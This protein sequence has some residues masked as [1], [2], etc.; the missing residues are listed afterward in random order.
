MNKSRIYIEKISVQGMSLPNAEIIFEKGVNI[1]TGASDSGKS[2]IF[3]C[4]DYVLGADAIPKD[5]PEADGYNDVYLQICTNK[6]ER[7]TLHRSLLYP[8]DIIYTKSNIEN[9]KLSKKETLGR[10]NNTKNGENIS[11]FLLNLIEV[12]DVYL[13]TNANNKTKK[14]SFRDIAK[15]TLVDESRII[16]ETSP[17]YLSPNNYL[18]FTYEKS[19]FRYLLTE[20]SDNSAVEIEEPKIFESRIK[21]KIEFI[22]FQIQNKN[23]LL[24]NII[25]EKT[26]ITS[27]ELQLKL[28][29]LLGK[30]EESSNKVNSLSE[31]RETY[32]IKLQ[33]IKSKTLY[34][35]E[36]LKRFFLLEEH[37]NNDL[38]RLEFILD[39]ESV[40]SQL[41]SKDCPV[42][43]TQLNENHLDCISNNSNKKQ[44]SESINI[45]YQKVK[46]KLDDLKETIVSTKS[47][48]VSNE[49]LIKTFESQI[50]EV[51]LEINEKLIP[52]KT[53]FQSEFDSI[54]NLKQLES[55]INSIYDEIKWLGNSKNGLEAEL[56]NKPKS[57]IANIDFE[58]KVL[59][60]F[61]DKVK[62]LLIDW[63]YS[64]HVTVI[65]NLKHRI[66]DIEIS[67][68]ARNSHGK[69]VRA[70][71]Y[72]SFILGLQDYCI[73]YDKPHPGFVILDSPLTTYHSNQKREENDEVTKD[74]QESFFE[75]LSTISDD[76]QIIIFDNKIP[77][78]KY[79]DKFS[80]IE[81]SKNDSSLR[82][83]FFNI[84]N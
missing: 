18:D 31:S 81:F 69:G 10:K 53:K 54:V 80:Y 67:G 32:F 39:G 7:Y 8:S 35:N 25:T 3:K 46:L 52:L 68:R 78:I 19:V 26:T 42:C 79:I 30:I 71:T 58:N 36:L 43:G 13:K 14:I 73:E 11:E 74:I 48:L 12:N 70:I 50:N 45:E 82:K 51:N 15:L 38:S 22:N 62:Q 47:E 64:D 57:S 34:L 33:T 72:T 65:F 29:E 76:R 9:F 2:Y 27:E 59:N 75:Y 1:I 21:G 24:E 17:I 4:I 55:K 49:D 84:R 56:L 28:D 77:D 40:L 66:F 60:E 83:G 5:I 44:L 37:Y 6:S 16:T 63:N 41:I 23:L 61:S 20:Q